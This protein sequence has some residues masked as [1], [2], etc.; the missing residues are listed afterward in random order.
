MVEGE[1][2]LFRV[3]D[4]RVSK[5]SWARPSVAYLILA[6]IV[7]QYLHGPVC[8][9]VRTAVF[10]EA[11]FSKIRSTIA[12]DSSFEVFDLADCIRGILR[13]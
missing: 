6:E 12:R 2:L 5:F 4:R 3:A 8:L 9:E 13:W 11:A 7:E 10:G 1:R